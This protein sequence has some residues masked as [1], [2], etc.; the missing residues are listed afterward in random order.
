MFSGTLTAIVTPFKP[1]ANGETEIDYASYEGL[2]E[3]QL[4]CG[5]SGLVVSGTT[6]ESAT[7]SKEEKIS[8][9][10]RTVEIV[11]KRVPVIAGTGSYATADSISMTRAAKDAGVDAAL[12]VSP[13][14]NKPTQE[15]LFQ[16]FSAVARE[17]GLPVVLYNIPGR[18]VVSIANETFVRLAKVP[19]IVGVKQAV[20]SACGLTELANIL[21]GKME[22]YAGDDPMTYLVMTLGGKGVISASASVIPE[23]M[24]AITSA[25][26]RGDF[27]SAKKA[28]WQA[29]PK[30]NALFVET[31]PIPAKAALKMFGKI[32]H[33]DVRLPLV[34]ASEKT[35]ELL[36]EVFS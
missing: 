24:V 13:Y 7:L 16:H 15:G 4:S 32:T 22:I 9:I 21:D 14:Y 34:K 23:E 33:E 31:N 26:I 36:K 10:K 1:L 35:R 27:E 3:W 12:V 2:I 17:G 5:V 18:C 20:D 28:Q 25:A 8:L 11:R 19:G 29:L 6:G 30:I